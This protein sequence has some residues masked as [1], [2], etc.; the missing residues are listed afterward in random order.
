M[1]ESK[2]PYVPVTHFLDIT[3]S[4]RSV[5]TA[6]REA[7]AALPSEYPSPS[8]IDL[9]FPG[10]NIIYG[11]SDYPNVFPDPDGIGGPP[12]FLKGP[13]APGRAVDAW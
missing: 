11:I 13:A 1:A 9:P 10:P 2:T 4:R 7:D 3:A 8:N 6:F 12:S 5:E